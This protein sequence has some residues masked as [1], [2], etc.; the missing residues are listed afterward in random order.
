MGCLE[1]STRESTVI[2]SDGDVGQYI[3]AGVSYHDGYGYFETVYSSLSGPVLAVND[4]MTGNIEIDGLLAS[5]QTLSVDVSAV[6]EMDWVILFLAGTVLMI[7]SGLTIE[8]SSSADYILSDDDISHYIKAS[9]SFEDG[10]GF[11]EEI[12]VYTDR[13]VLGGVSGRDPEEQITGTDGEEHVDGSDADD[14]ID[15]GGGDDQIDAGGGADVIDAGEGNDAIYLEADAIWSSRYK[16]GRIEWLEDGTYEIAEKISL[17][18]KNRFLDVIDGNSDYDTVYLTDD[19]RGDAF[20]L[21]DFFSDFN[22]RSF[23]AFVVDI[24]G[25]TGTTRMSSVERIIG[26]DGNDIIDMTSP[27]FVV[28]NMEI[29]GNDGADVLWGND[30]NDILD[31]GLGSD[32][33]AGGRGSD[34]FVVR[35]GEHAHSYELADHVRD[36]EIG[37]DSIA[38]SGGLSFDDLKLEVIG[39]GTDAGKVALVHASHDFIYTVFDN[40]GSDDIALLSQDVGVYVNDETVS[41]TGTAEEDQTLELDISGISSMSEEASL[42]VSWQS[43]REDGLWDVIVEGSDL[44]LILDQEHVGKA[45]RAVATYKDSFG[46]VRSLATEVTDTVANINDLPTGS[47]VIKGDMLVGNHLSYD[48]SSLDDEDGLGDPQAQW[49]YTDNGQVWFEVDVEDPSSLYLDNSLLG[50]QVRLA[51][52]YTDGWGHTEKVYSVV[53][54]PVYGHSNKTIF[55]AEEDDPENL[56]D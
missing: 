10:Q 46:V 12:S 9:L 42:K 53:T 6:D 13:T 28:N 20:F 43:L 25:D 7:I 49:E 33:L 18:G 41:I 21:H 51:T 26:G 27:D 15:A 54:D 3:R 56:H 11:T 48:L 44:T 45:I 24:L 38:L 23:T 2:L 39:S 36:F 31:G 8:T 35:M 4:P 34:L 1:G 55:F 37:N 19:I 40:L 52:T 14:D 47:P 32:I 29:Q 30:G 22:A 17:D 5:G 50:K 16:A